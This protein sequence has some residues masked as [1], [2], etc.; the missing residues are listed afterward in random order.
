MALILL[1]TYLPRADREPPKI[2]P[3]GR[4]LEFAREKG[5]DLPEV[6][7]LAL[8]A[9]KQ[10]AMFL[11]RAK[12]AGKLPPGLGEEQIHRLQRRGSPVFQANVAAIQ[13]Y[14]PVTL[15]LASEVPEDAPADD[16]EAAWRLL[17]PSI[18]IHRAEG[19][20]E[21]MIRAPLA[22]PLAER[23]FL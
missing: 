1:D 7:F 16:R 3:A 2:D 21:S 6:E 17:A 12:A 22:K 23:I 13:R 19:S 9:D 8:T 11:E 18:T 4:M 15:F 14:G 5:I 20:H 10:L